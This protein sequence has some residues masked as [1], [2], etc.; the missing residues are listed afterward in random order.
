MS[1]AHAAGS[2]LQQAQA[3]KAEYM[4]AANS[5]HEDGTTTPLTRQSPARSPESHT[6][7]MGSANFNHGSELPVERGTRCWSNLLFVGCWGVRQGV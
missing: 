6:T 5:D 2:A 7:N 3:F 4:S 1:K